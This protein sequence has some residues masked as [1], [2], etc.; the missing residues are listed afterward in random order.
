MFLS[1]DLLSRPDFVNARDQVQV[2][3]SEGF[4]AFVVLSLNQRKAGAPRRKPQQQKIPLQNEI[5]K[6]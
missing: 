3:H 4:A 5:K 1:V 6:K 2:L